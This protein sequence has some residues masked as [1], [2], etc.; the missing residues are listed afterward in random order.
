MPSSVVGSFSDPDAFAASIHRVNARVMVAGRGR[1][2][3]SLERIDLRLLWMQRFS[4]CL[5]RILRVDVQPR[6]VY[7]LFRTQPGPEMSWGGV[8]T[9]YAELAQFLGGSSQLFRTTGPSR[10]ATMS[11]PLEDAQSAL[12]AI[13]GRDL[14]PALRSAGV[15]PPAQALAKLQRLHAA[16]REL[17]RQTPDI[18][19]K[20][21]A[22][23]GLEQALIEAWAACLDTDN[24]VEDT[25]ARRRHTAIMRR[26]HAVIEANVGE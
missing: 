16:A 26:F 4:E 6:R 5:P 1:F 8:E 19:A 10:W 23:R 20:A 13:A 21:A 7:L 9:T 22:A 25:A 18:F 24:V 17:A 3:A 11:L 14:I 15:A 12:A 2:E